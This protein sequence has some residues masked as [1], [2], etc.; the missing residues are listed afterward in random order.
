MI[1]GIIYKIFRNLCSTRAFVLCN[2]AVLDLKLN[3]TL[4]ERTFERG[5]S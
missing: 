1:L 2:A 3:K 5:C 4:W